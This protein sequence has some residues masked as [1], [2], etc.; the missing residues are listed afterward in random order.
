MLSDSGYVKKRIKTE[1]TRARTFH[2]DCDL[3]QNSLQTSSQIYWR[4][5]REVENTEKQCIGKRH[6][7]KNNPL[8]DSSAIKTH[9]Q[10]FLSPAEW[11]IRSQRSYPDY[12]RKKS[13]QMYLNWFICLAV[14]YTCWLYVWTL[15]CSHHSIDNRIYISQNQHNNTVHHLYD[16]YA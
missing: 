14:A 16:C 10:I 5:Y 8:I 3:M 12:L 6:A 2:L 9:F 11:Q 13:P 1:L 15:K 4:R 7:T